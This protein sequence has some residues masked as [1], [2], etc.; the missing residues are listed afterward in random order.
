MIVPIATAMGVDINLLR[1]PSSASILK[2]R[3]SDGHN[4]THWLSR[5]IRRLPGK[6]RK[7][8]GRP[9]PDLPAD[10]EREMALLHSCRVRLPTAKAERLLGF[11]PPIPFA[12]G[13]R[14]SIEWLRVEGYVA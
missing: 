1:T 12:E 2:R 11:S 6:I 3:P 7:V 13:C 9:A 4:R 5:R 14:R 8:V 10:F